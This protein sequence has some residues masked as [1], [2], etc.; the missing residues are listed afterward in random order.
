MQRL[1][2]ESQGIAITGLSGRFAGAA[3]PRDVWK[4]ILRKQCRLT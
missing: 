3:T 2:A 4:A 1:P